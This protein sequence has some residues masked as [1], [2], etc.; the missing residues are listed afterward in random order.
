MWDVQHQVRQVRVKARLCQARALVIQQHAHI[1][2]GQQGPCEASH[3]SLQTPLLILSIFGGHGLVRCLENASLRS[4]E[5]RRHLEFVQ[6][7]WT[8]AE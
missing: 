1:D 2:P 8:F 6:A 4:F 5:L 7:F 3:A